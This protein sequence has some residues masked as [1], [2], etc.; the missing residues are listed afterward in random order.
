[1]CSH[2]IGGLHDRIVRGQLSW[3]M[4][5]FLTSIVV[6]Q[7]AALYGL[8]CDLVGELLRCLR[9]LEKVVLGCLFFSLFIM[10]VGQAEWSLKGYMFGDRV[11]LTIS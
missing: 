4:G 5:R 10:N 7:V 8:I 9:P 2:L 6:Q 11:C 3:N 1:M